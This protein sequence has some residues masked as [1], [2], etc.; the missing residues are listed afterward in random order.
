MTKMI[1]AFIAEQKNAKPQD[2]FALADEISFSG[3]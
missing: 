2:I 1:K 3:E